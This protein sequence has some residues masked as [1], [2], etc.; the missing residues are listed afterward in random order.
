MLNKWVGSNRWR[1][2]W[3]SLSNFAEDTENALQ[4]VV[5]TI[6]LLSVCL[7]CDKSFLSDQ[8]PSWTW[9]IYFVYISVTCVS[10]AWH[11][12]KPIID[13]GFVVPYAY[14]WISLGFPECICTSV[15]I[16]YTT[17][18]TGFPTQLMSPCIEREQSY[19]DANTRTFVQG[20]LNW[21]V[22]LW[23]TSSYIFGSFIWC[24]ECLWLQ[25]C[26][27]FE[28]WCYIIFHRCGNKSTRR[29]K[30]RIA[31]A[32]NDIDDTLQSSVCWT[33]SLIARF[34]RPTWGPPGATMWVTWS[35]LFG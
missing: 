19:T 11:Q 27:W 21:S 2:I 32:N 26:G 12:G 5:F 20:F 28:P 17:P 33:S 16:H 18:K 10:I 15:I 14:P 3:Y 1:W 22:E 8:F 34:M 35:L 4:Y 25:S 9:I 7:V 31:H 24:Y 6:I 23:E 30:R 29:V 13:D